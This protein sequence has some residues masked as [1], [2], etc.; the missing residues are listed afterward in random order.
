MKKTAL[1]LILL[2][3]RLAFYQ[4]VSSSKPGGNFCEEMPDPA[5]ADP[6]EYD[7]PLIFPV[8]LEVQLL[9]G[10]FSIDSNTFILIPQNSGKTDEFLARIIA[11]EF[12]DKYEVPV[13]ISRKPVFTDK[14]K[15]ILIG[16]ITNPLVKFWCDQK[17]LTTEL[18]TLGDEG[19]I[20]SVTSNNIVVAANSSRGTLF[21]LESL[22]QLIKLSDGKLIVPQV[23]VKDSPVYPLRGI[24]LYL[25][26]TGEYYIL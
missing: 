4:D 5:K 23:R 22:R 9:E 16:D 6:A 15:S 19:Y 2:A 14:D 18:K 8:P 3:G 24:K 13:M 26:G 10:Q 12:A 11:N 20:L 1:I 21:G 7:E 17:K 25:P